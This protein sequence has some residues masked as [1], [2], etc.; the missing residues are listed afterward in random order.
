MNHSE[1]TKAAL[2]LASE[3]TALSA[4][5]ILLLWRKGLLQD[6]DAETYE[7]RLRSIAQAMEGFD[8]DAAAADLWTAANLL[9]RQSPTGQE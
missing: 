8:C 5:L 2:H 1:A 6:A 4:G 3:A 7:A 9:R